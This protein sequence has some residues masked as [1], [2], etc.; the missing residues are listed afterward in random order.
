MN[1]SQRATAAEEGRDLADALGDRF[2]SRN[3]R[4]WLGVA[5][6]LQGDLTQA[7]EVIRAVADEAE[8]A[9][10]LTMTVFAAICGA[11]LCIP[12]TRRQPRT[13]R[14]NPP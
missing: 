1:R 12:G 2:F 8:A 7:S 9:G 14:R 3:Y 6:M 10:D 11:A 4:L 5:L 13:P